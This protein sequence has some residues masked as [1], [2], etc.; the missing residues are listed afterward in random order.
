MPNDVNHH[1]EPHRD[2]DAANPDTD[3]LIG[4]WREHLTGDRAMPADG[5]DE[6]EDHL[7]VELQRFDPTGLTPQEKLWV[8]AGRV[9]APNVL[10]EQFRTERPGA[11]WALRLRW[12]VA[13]YLVVGLLNLLVFSPVQHFQILGFQLGLGMNAP[14]SI[15]L[16]C[17]G[18][19]LTMAVGLAVA[20]PWCAARLGRGTTTVRAGAL[21]T[22]PAFLYAGVVLIPW[23]YFLVYQLGF[24]VPLARQMS[25]QAISQFAIVSTVTS[26]VIPF[27]AP[28][29]ILILA[30]ALQRRDRRVRPAA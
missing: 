9:G 1:P 6:L 16:T 5:V 11:A 17:L 25:L 29:S 3:R 23:I 13:G 19:S 10:A 26:A 7:R 4:Q 2:H 20:I 22:R 14:A 8:A 21:L 28:L 12:M 30:S 15:A 18:I 27:A 24:F